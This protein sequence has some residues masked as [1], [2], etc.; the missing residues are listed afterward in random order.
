MASWDLRSSFANTVLSIHARKT[1]LSFQFSIFYWKGASNPPLEVP[2]SR[3]GR[4]SSP[5]T[6][7]I[8]KCRSPLLATLTSIAFAPGIRI[9]VYSSTSARSW[10]LRSEGQQVRPKIGTIKSAVHYITL[11]RSCHH[12]SCTCPALINM[13]DLESRWSSL[14]QYGQLIVMYNA[15]SIDQ[16]FMFFVCFSLFC[17]RSSF[18]CRF[19]FA[20]HTF[21]F[22]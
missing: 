1:L 11:T 15:L 13:H 14:Q 12:N 9:S 4:A 7:L 2:S 18:F 17:R 3:K 21:V 8:Q 6:P 19:V 16:F 5:Q 20:S 10:Q 22:F